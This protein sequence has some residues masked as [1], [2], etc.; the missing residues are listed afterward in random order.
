MASHLYPEVLAQ[1]NMMLMVEFFSSL[2]LGPLLKKIL[3]IFNMYMFIY[4]IA[5]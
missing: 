1:K 4:W 3:F 5:I 2:V